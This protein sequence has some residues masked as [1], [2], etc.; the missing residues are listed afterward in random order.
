[1]YISWDKAKEILKAG[2]VIAVPTDTVYGL[3]GS[4]GSLAAIEKIYKIKGRDFNKPLVVMCSDISKVK[5]LVQGWDS[6][7]EKLAN[8]YWP[9]ALT[10]IFERNN[11]VPDKIVNGQATVG[12]RIPAHEGLLDLL[13]ASGEPL[14]VTSANRSGDAELV[15][16]AQVEKE[17]SSEIAGVVADDASQKGQ[18]ST[19][20]DVSVTPWKVLREGP[21]KIK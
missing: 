2:E 3:A 13:K 19:I 18:P 8:K 15:K 5:E 1:M 20:L 14:V 21:I 16:A 7:I 11:N 12:I 9:G 17:F 4:A 10:L 6:K